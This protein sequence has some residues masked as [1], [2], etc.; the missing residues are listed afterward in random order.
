[1]TAA[2]NNQSQNN[3]LIKI[4]M[5]YDEL[6]S[7]R[8]R[9]EDIILSNY[10]VPHMPALRTLTLREDDVLIDTFPKCGTT[11][12]QAIV[13][14]IMN[15]CDTTFSGGK[16]ITS[17]VPMLEFPLNFYEDRVD[18]ML[19]GEVPLFDWDSLKS[20]RLFK[21]HIPFHLLPD[22]L[23]TRKVT[24][25]VICITR[26]PKDVV[27][28][29]Y[30]FLRSIKYPS[31]LKNGY[32]HY[33]FDQFFHDFFIAENCQYGSYWKHTKEFWEISHWDN[34]LFLHFETML[35]DL[36]SQVKAVA[37]FLGKELTEHQINTIIEKTTFSKM[38]SDTP[39]LTHIQ[40]GNFTMSMMRKG[41][42]RIV[43]TVGQN[44]LVDKLYETHFGKIEISHNF[45]L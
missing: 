31:F 13:W 15:N 6:P 2:Q 17:L 19:R 4:M 37:G 8:V 33:T 42:C 16:S 26:N 35:K 12:M 21:T 39:S 27:V 34:V 14:L 43:L 36:R 23:Q 24:P 40:R 9:Y 5:S 11:W 25:K 3:E 28:S 22:D 7:P 30:H 29:F 10:M 44:E 32:D 1:M 45:N 38:K 41:K 20:P 18:E